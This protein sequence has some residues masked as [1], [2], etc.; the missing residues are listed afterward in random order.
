M[1]QRVRQK[2][3]AALAAK[4][5]ATL[6]NINAAK[7]VADQVVSGEKVSHWS[8][9]RPGRTWT[10]QPPQESCAGSRVSFSTAFVDGSRLRKVSS[11]RSS[12]KPL[13]GACRIDIDRDGHVYHPFAEC[14]CSS[15]LFSFTEFA[16][17]RS[18]RFLSVANV[19][20]NGS[21][22]HTHL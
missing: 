22:R 8:T 18:E 12:K 16:V 6:S 2:I 21:C 14:P 1:N 10:Q 3:E 13:P 4:T 17:V 7:S 20:G 5:N 15:L 11:T 19:F 9:L